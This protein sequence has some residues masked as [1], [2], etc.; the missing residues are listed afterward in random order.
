MHLAIFPAW[1]RSGRTRRARWHAAQRHGGRRVVAADALHRGRYVPPVAHRP[2]GR[3]VAHARGA[4]AAVALDERADRRDRAPADRGSDR[5][6]VVAAVPGSD[7]KQIP[8]PGLRLQVNQV[9]WAKMLGATRE[10]INRQL[11]RLRAAGVIR[12]EGNEIV[13]VSL[14]TC[15]GPPR[16]RSELPGT[17]AGGVAPGSG[18]WRGAREVR[19]CRVTRPSE[20][21]AAMPR[22][23]APTGAPCA[24]PYDPVGPRRAAWLARASPV[25]RVPGPS[26]TSLD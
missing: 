3:H 7:G 11:S 10:S 21:A 16:R 6:A 24:P 23:V 8:P 1:A 22:R 5:A 12:R 9:A 4:R 14:R 20:A 17:G 19:P 18:R 26:S 15:F 2:P 13:L 25:L